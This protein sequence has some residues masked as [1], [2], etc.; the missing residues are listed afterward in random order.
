[1]ALPNAGVPLSLDDI[2]VEILGTTGTQ[3]SLNDT[4]VRALISSTVGTQVSISDYYGASYNEF[5]GLIGASDTG[6][7]FLYGFQTLNTGTNTVL[8]SEALHTFNNMRESTQSDMDA[9][10]ASGQSSP[11]NTYHHIPGWKRKGSWT[12]PSE[13]TTGYNLTSN[14]GGWSYTPTGI[15]ASTRVVTILEY[16]IYCRNTNDTSATNRFEDHNGLALGWDGLNFGGTTSSNDRNR[17]FSF[18]FNATDV[19]RGRAFNGN[20]SDKNNILNTRT[21]GRST[22]TMMRADTLNGLYDVHYSNNGGSVVNATTGSANIITPTAWAL[23]HLNSEEISTLGGTFGT[24]NQHSLC[25]GFLYVDRQISTTE[26]ANVSSWLY[27]NS[28]VPNH[29]DE[30]QYIKP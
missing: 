25:Q 8:G 22:L 12:H 21:T 26:M 24:C 10:V 15:S 7:S 5:A 3:V 6:D 14:S 16:R 23:H 1:M 27:N 9:L 18:E 2:H 28:G 20:Y 30:T 29:T 19:N 11:N 17:M 4:D 13:S